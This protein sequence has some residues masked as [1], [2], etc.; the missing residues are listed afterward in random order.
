MEKLVECILNFFDPPS[1]ME[2]RMER[3]WQIRLRKIEN[4]M[5]NKIKENE[6]I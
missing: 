2:K 4:E 1:Q 6:N 5:L 3:R